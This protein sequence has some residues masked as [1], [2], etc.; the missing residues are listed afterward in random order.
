MR[1]L[2]SRSQYC[3][4]CWAFAT[5]S[6]LADRVKIK[7]GVGAPD[8]DLSVQQVL[9]C[10]G[11][12]AG[13]CLGG[14][15]VAVY[16]WLY[17]QNIRLAV[18]S[19]NPY[20]ACS[21]D[22]PEGFCPRIRDLT[23][24]KSANIARNC[25][26]FVASG[27]EC[28]GLSTYP[29][30]T[31]SAYGT[32]AGE[33]PIMLEVYARGP[34]ACGVDADP[35]VDYVGGVMRSSTLDPSYVP[36]INH[37][38]SIVGWGVDGEMPY[39]LVR[40][41]WGEAWGEMGFFRVERGVNALGI[42]T[43]CAWAVPKV[44]PVPGEAF[45]CDEEGHCTGAHTLSAHPHPTMATVLAAAHSRRVTSTAAEKTHVAAQGVLRP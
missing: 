26:T 32:V 13:S 27:G 39:W 43:Q 44:Y 34:V 37:V 36:Q 41:S 18:E 5:T 6:A 3:G 11:Q 45:G 4:A 12:F 17:E 25:D 42:E 30:V 28:V 16:Q 31:I 2:A 8:V 15:E 40:N 20:L 38:V 21:S 9:N 22:S 23:T 1:R 19:V 7:R 10:A 24:C 14:D 35:I 29:N 33:H